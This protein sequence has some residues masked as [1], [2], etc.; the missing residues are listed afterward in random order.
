VGGGVERCQGEH[1]RCGLAEE[2]PSGEGRHTRV[3]AARRAQG[4][5]GEG[6]DH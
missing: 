5:G 3:L 6:G 2:P 1:L 4:V